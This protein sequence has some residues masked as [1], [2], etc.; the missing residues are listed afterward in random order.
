MMKYE[1]STT[2]TFEGETWRDARNGGYFQ[3]NMMTGDE[4][5]LSLMVRYWGG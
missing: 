2:G 4:S 3:Y 1:N 5:D